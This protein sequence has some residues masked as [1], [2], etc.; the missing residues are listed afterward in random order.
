[1]TE[2]LRLK[3][4]ADRLAGKQNKQAVFFGIGKARELADRYGVVLD[5]VNLVRRNGKW[6]YD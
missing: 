6:D 3:I 5:D 2:R 1:M 4:Q